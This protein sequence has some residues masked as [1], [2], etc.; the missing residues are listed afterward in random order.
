MTP[1]LFGAR[2]AFRQDNPRIVP[3]SRL[4]LQ[5]GREGPEL[6]RRPDPELVQVGEQVSG[7]VIDP[8]GAG[9]L[10]LLLAV[11]ARKQPHAQGAGPLGRE[12]I[13]DA[14]ADY[15]AVA[16]RHAQSLRRSE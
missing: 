9:S 2:E 13:P 6:A 8:V 15:E 10:Q 7:V 3:V 16:R 5:R 4:P 1:P 12:Q 11:A 14:V